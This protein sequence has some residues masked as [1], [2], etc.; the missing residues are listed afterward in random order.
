MFAKRPDGSMES[1]PSDQLPARHCAADFQQAISFSI[2]ARR[3]VGFGISRMAALPDAYISRADLARQSLAP[4]SR[5]T[6]FRARY[7]FVLLN[8][9]R[10]SMAILSNPHNEQYQG[11]FRIESPYCGFGERD[12]CI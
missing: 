6:Q 10:R 12:I 5:G 1:S 7:H 9:R 11:L 2:D 3:R 4:R 8:S